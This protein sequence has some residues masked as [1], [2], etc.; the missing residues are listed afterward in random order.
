MATVFTKLAGNAT[1]R[2]RRY[3][4]ATPPEPRKKPSYFPWNTGWLIG[5][6]IMV[7]FNPYITG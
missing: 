2:M 7:Y 3:E 5:I 1:A 4:A 6:L